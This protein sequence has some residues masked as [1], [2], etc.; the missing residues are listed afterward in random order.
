MSLEYNLQEIYSSVHSGELVA[1]F[2]GTHLY[3][4]STGWGYLWKWF[5]NVFGCIFNRE[6][7]LQKAIVKTHTIFQDKL[8]EVTQYVE[9][10]RSYLQQKCEEYPVDDIEFTQARKGITS[11]NRKTRQFQKLVEQKNSKLMALFA[12]YLNYDEEKGNIPF[13]N[14]SSETCK[15]YQMFIDLEGVMHEPIPFYILEKLSA[16]KQMNRFLEGCTLE[17]YSPQMFKKE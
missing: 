6:E 17:T 11:W 9:K 8:K 13:S 15:D 2:K 1:N 16:G 7:K 10:Y 4:T 3:N 14:P 5:Y 12:K